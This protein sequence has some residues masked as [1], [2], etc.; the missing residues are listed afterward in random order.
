MGGQTATF[1]KVSELGAYRWTVKALEL[2]SRF[3]DTKLFPAGRRIMRFEITGA[4]HSVLRAR[5]EALKAR[6]TI[7]ML[8]CASSACAPPC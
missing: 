6:A 3:E 5:M 2:R 1:L 7:A 8:M 4:R